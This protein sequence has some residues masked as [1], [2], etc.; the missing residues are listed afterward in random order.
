M[1]LEYI[2]TQRPYVPASFP[3]AY[4]R[5]LNKC[6]TRSLIFSGLGFAI[7]VILVIFHMRVGLNDS[8]MMVA[9]VLGV[10]VQGLA[11]LSLVLQPMSVMPEIFHFKK[12]SMDNFIKEIDHDEKI[13]DELVSYPKEALASTLYWLTVKID[14]IERRVRA[15]VGDKTAVLSLVVLAGTLLKDAGAL[16]LIGL[17]F[18][19]QEGSYIHMLIYW[20]FSFLLGGAIGALIYKTAGER[21]RY[22]RELTQA[23][24]ERQSVP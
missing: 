4:E 7:L 5:F 13:V 8:W 20:F 21:L 6:A 9:L 14:R 1:A 19:M 18:G 17:D 3:S 2:V 12:R 22:Y 16:G 11:L 10:A 24:L 23:A 15:F